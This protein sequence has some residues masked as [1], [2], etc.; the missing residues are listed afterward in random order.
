GGVRRCSGG[1][2]RFDTLRGMA[3]F[4]L[5]A[6]FLAPII[7]AFAGAGVVMLHRSAGVV[8]LRKGFQ[9][10]WLIWQ[11]WVLSNAL[12][13][14]TLLPMLVIGRTRARGW[15]RRASLR[16]GMEAGLLGLGL[17]FVGTLVFVGPYGGQSSLPARLYAPLPFVLWAAV[18]FGSS[19]A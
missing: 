3:G 9:D 6:V 7:A 17:L 2:P 16:Q 19:G 11:A 4:L 8:S 18:R 14:L 15:L 10:Y 1:S 13:G 12:T 5:F